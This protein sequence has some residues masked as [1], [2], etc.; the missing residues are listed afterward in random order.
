MERKLDLIVL[1]FVCNAFK[2]R[3]SGAKMIRLSGSFMV[4]LVVAVDIKITNL[5]YLLKIC[6]GF[7]FA[8]YS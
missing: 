4:R 5:R 8:V 3:V 6:K 7:Y 1:Q 2:C